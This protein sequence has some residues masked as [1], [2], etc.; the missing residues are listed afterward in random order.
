[1]TESLDDFLAQRKATPLETRCICCKNEELA[2]DILRWLNLL[3][4]GETE[5]PLHCL[6]YKHLQPKYKRPKHV[7]SARSHITNCLRRSA[8]TGKPLGDDA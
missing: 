6:F 5:V 3:E 4:R 2:A 8:Q 1:M 7:S